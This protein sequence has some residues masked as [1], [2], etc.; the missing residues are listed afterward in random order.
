MLSCTSSNKLTWRKNRWVPQNLDNLK[1]GQTLK[2]G[3]AS[4][5][6]ANTLSLHNL[7]VWK[8]IPISDGLVIQLHICSVIKIVH[9]YKIRIQTLPNSMPS[10]WANNSTTHRRLSL[11]IEWLVKGILV[12]DFF[13]LWLISQQNILNKSCW[14][15]FYVLF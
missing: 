4:Y 12:C 2:C 7:P 1:N 13:C 10:K 15:C 8:K 14:E 3:W 11:T 5:P 6:N 9:I